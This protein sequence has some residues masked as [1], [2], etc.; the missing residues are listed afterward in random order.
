M[1]STVDPGT[2][3]FL[4]FLIPGWGQMRRGKMK[5]GLAWLVVV[6]AGYI[7]LVVPGLILHLL[8]MLDAYWRK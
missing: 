7:L 4:S 5:Q 3:A 1:R 6:L 8:C 2:S